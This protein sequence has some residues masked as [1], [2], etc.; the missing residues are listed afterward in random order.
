MRRVNPKSLENLI[1][2][3]RPSAF[4]EPKQ[5]RHLTITETGWKG[6][7]VVARAMGCKNGNVSELL[8]K[9]GRGELVVSV[10]EK[11]V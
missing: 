7:Q 6:T 3:G 2:E 9:I 8:E 1:H 5:R 11:S 4:D 10:P